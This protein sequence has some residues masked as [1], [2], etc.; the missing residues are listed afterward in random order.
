MPSID[1]SDWAALRIETIS[2]FAVLFLLLAV[3]LRLTWNALARD[4]PALPVLTF[5]RALAAVLVLSL[6]LAVVLTMIAGARELLTP[7]AW[8]KQG[9]TYRLSEP[10]P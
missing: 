2:F 9:Q 6:L 1:L 8:Q 7:G 5:R 4:F 10:K 3:V